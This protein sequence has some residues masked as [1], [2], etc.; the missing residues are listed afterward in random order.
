MDPIFDKI[1]TILIDDYSVDPQTLSA[2]NSLAED[3]DM[4]S[5]ELTEF[6]LTLEE[7]F[8]VEINDDMLTGSMTV[9]DVVEVI[10]KL[11]G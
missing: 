9:G 11:K 6:A 5:V 8:D 2:D 1:R 3:L 7:D 4:D 10:R